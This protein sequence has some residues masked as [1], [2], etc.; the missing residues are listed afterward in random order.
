M[1]RCP[2]CTPDYCACADF[3]QG[4]LGYWKGTMM[5]SEIADLI[6]GWG[7]DEGKPHA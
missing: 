4:R 7:T 5:M 2:S 1:T 3:Y 6:A